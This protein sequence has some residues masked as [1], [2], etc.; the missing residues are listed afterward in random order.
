MKPPMRFG[1]NQRVSL[2]V[3]PLV[4]AMLVLAVAPIR[5]YLRLRAAMDDV[6]RE[7]EFV[8]ELCRFDIQAV[9]QSVGYFGVAFRDEDPRQIEELANGARAALDALARSEFAP[10]Q[11]ERLDGIERAYARLAEAG[12]RAVDLARRGEHEA[13]KRLVTATLEE[14]RDAHLL[15][16]V[17][18][19]QIEGSL[20]LRQA[21][22]SLLAT[23]A[24]LALVPP[25]AGLE[26][27]ARGLRRE[28]AETIA[29]ARF[30]RQAQRLLGEYRSFAF[31]GESRRELAVAEHELDNAYMVWEAQVAAGDGGGAT[32]SAGMAD[33]GTE[34]RAVKRAIDR[35][36]ALDHEGAQA[37][38]LHVYEA[39]LE[40]LGN[41]SLPRV[42]TAAFDAH[43]A[44]LSTLLDS[45][46]TQS[47]IGG[48]ALVAAALLALGLALV[49]PWLISRWVVRPVIALTRATRE[50]AAGGGGGPVSVHARGEVAELA[51]SFNRMAERLAERTRELEAERARERLRHAERLA[52]VGSL[53]GGLAHQINNP[54]NNILLT[55]EH[56]LGEEGPEAAAA[57]RDALA[58]SADEAKRCERI[59]R[60][61]VAFSRGEPGERG[62]EDANQVLRRASDLTAGAAAA[63]RA[64]VELDLTGEPVPILASPIALEQALVN[65]IRNAIQSK[66]GARVVLRTER[67]ADRVRIE[68][69]DDG[70]G[71]DRA[72]LGRLFDPFYTTRADQGGIGLGLSVAHRIVT[73]HG[74]EIR[75][76]SRSGEGTAVTVHLPLDLPRESR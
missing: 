13:A 5:S 38:A 19:A 33:V 6:R 51:A 74:G 30:A 17:D 70:H 15:P 18:A 76:A 63:H 57:W 61:L 64:T 66:A 16:L 46:A 65:V 71:M 45:I 12:D 69:R 3:V 8:L 73:D 36:A 41:E 21:L 34:Y 22:D 2:I 52:A 35:L 4:A 47:R 49:C 26:A 23:S 25:L 39:Q 31:F 7:L 54:L 68:V 58:A 29:V 11:T 32:I 42:V 59:V 28:A 9:R 20:A 24:Q 53:A 40:P 60:G 10:R 37:S 1:L 55:A 43:E 67:V 14:Q 50:L 56:A 75:V 62:R 48:A 72:A 27:D 44:R